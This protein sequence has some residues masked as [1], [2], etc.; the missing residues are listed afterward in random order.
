MINELGEKLQG[1]FKKLKGFGKLD[2]K[3]IADALREV[4]LALLSADVHFSIAKE[5]CDRV[6]LKAVGTEFAKTIRPGDLFVKIVHD[7][8]LATFQEGSGG[9]PTK[10]PLTILM[11]GLNGAGKTTTSGKLAA[12]LKKKGERPF[13]VAADLTRPAAI[14]QLATLG[15]QIGVPVI[16][17]Q[18]GETLEPFLQ[19]AKSAAVAERC[20]ILIVDTAGRTEVDETLQAELRRVH[21]L[22]EPDET[23]LVAD[24]ATGQTAVEVAKA[25]HSNA[26]VTGLV[27]SKFDGDA[28]GGAALSLQTVTGCP[29][30]FLGVGEKVDAL[31]EFAPE[32]LVDRMLGMGDVVGLVERAQEAMADA[33]MEEMAKRM[34]SQTFNLQDFLDQMKMLK[35]LGPLQNVLGMLPGINNIPN[36]AVDENALKRTEAI[37]LSMTRKERK[38]PDLLNARRRQRIASGSGT[39][40]TEVNELMR[41]FRMMKKVMGRFS[42]GKNQ[43]NM[44]KRLMGGMPGSQKWN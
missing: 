16:R 8:L 6:K 28:R 11:C 17:P 37:I 41:R 7:E 21:A 40:V 30:R 14:D 3:N 32:R 42:K 15:E 31:E 19:R 20:G 18:A 2:E 9:L 36:S 38:N 26:G 24:A 1:I 4:R 43:E 29:I 10:R 13:L 5:F 33:D 39:S 44:I 35:K 34:Q 23:L 27:L 25:F 12:Y 22:V